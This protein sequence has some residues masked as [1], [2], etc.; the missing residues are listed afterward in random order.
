MARNPVSQVPGFISF[1]QDKRAQIRTKTSKAETPRLARETAGS[2]RVTTGRPTG[3]SSGIKKNSVNTSKSSISSS[4][5]P[6]LSTKRTESN[7][8]TPAGVDSKTRNNV[9]TKVPNATYKTDSNPRPAT[10]VPSSKTTSLRS[11]TQ[12]AQDRISKSG[13][14]GSPYS[15]TKPSVSWKPETSRSQQPAPRQST[16]SK[17]PSRPTVKM[18]EEMDRISSSSEESLHYS[19][20]FEDYE[21]DFEEYVGSD[22]DDVVEKTPRQ[23]EKPTG[24]AA[25][26]EE[27]THDSGTYDM[28]AAPHRTDHM[29]TIQEKARAE[30]LNLDF[31][32]GDFNSLVSKDEGFEDFKKEENSLSSLQYHQFI[33]F[34]TV[35]KEE[36]KQKKLRK[37]ELRARKLLSM[38][39][40][41]QKGGILMNMSP[42]P[43]EIYMQCYGRSNTLQISTQT[44]D[45]RPST[46]VQTEEEEKRT[47]WTQI[48]GPIKDNPNNAT[49]LN[50]APTLQQT[51]E[52]VGDD[53]MRSQEAIAAD[54][55]ERNIYKLD[56]KRLDR[57]LSIAGK[58][59]LMLLERNSRGMRHGSYQLEKDKSLEFSKGCIPLR[60]ERIKFL[61]NRPVTSVVLEPTRCTQCLTV[62]TPTPKNERVDTSENRTILCVWNIAEPSKPTKLL[63][64]PTDLSCCGFNWPHPHLIQAGLKEGSIAVWDTKEAAGFHQRVNS[65]DENSEWVLRVPS[66][67]TAA[68][69][70]E[71]NH[72][73]PIVGLESI[74]HELQSTDNDRSPSQ[75]CSLDQKGLIII[76]TLVQTGPASKNPDQGQAYWSKIKLVKSKTLHA[77]ENIPSSLMDDRS[78]TSLTLQDQHVFVTTNTAQIVR[79][80]FASGSSNRMAYRSHTDEFT[81]IESVKICPFEGN[82]FLA[83]CENGGIQLYF[84]KRCTPL[85]CFF[86]AIETNG[87]GIKSI[88]WSNLKPGVFF[89][90]DSNSSIHLWDLCSSDM[91]PYLSIPFPDRRITS[92]STASDDFHAAFLAFSTID[93]AVELHQLKEEWTGS[94]KQRFERDL[95][96]FTCYLNV[97]L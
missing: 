21:S 42:I 17:V 45:N 76:W 68:K 72:L 28:T 80:S 39:R 83:G 24:K 67:I 87:S 62:H 91:H 89:V 59:I 55:T 70:N 15:S 30:N 8:K 32:T 92:I 46:E 14:K 20:D 43:Y 93:G 56:G 36:R 64:T 65:E 79:K 60:T 41:D 97:L 22:D 16:A 85:I 78:A 82:Y 88:H 47:K 27:M 63:T 35:S 3:T 40:L 38:F 49:G 74:R 2:V 77:F 6:T 84:Q 53:S 23:E 48:P 37:S 69:V 33:T 90:L 25:F 12:V 29:Q 44:E 5:R 75:I 94:D 57:F 71:T 50:R 61:R 54:I 1:E 10:S 13:P 26:G 51:R 9:S 52:G 7:P 86:G 73:E 4:S 31:I 95:E 96:K 19:D 11:T 81:G 34:E 66:Y 58:R 18:K